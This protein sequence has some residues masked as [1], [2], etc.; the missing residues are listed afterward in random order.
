MIQCMDDI[1]FYCAVCLNSFQSIDVTHLV[2]I[3]RVRTHT[4]TINVTHVLWNE[5]ERDALDNVTQKKELAHTQ[6]FIWHANISVYQLVFSIEVGSQI[7]Q[8]SS[9]V[10]CSSKMYKCPVVGLYIDT[11]KEIVWDIFMCGVNVS[12]PFR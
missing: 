4:H 9:A 3:S 10:P 2:A 5:L 11:F 12:V 6:T 1:D 8:C 7:C